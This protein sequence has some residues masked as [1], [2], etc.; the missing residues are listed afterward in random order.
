M[1]SALSIDAVILHGIVKSVTGEKISPDLSDEESDLSPRIRGFLQQQVQEALKFGRQIVEVDGLSTV[2]GLIRG[3]WSGEHDLVASSRALAQMLQDSQPVVSPEG[4]LMVADATVDGRKAFVIAKLEHE[5]GAQAK[6]EPNEEGRMVYTM[7]FLDDLFF[8]TGSRVF[9]IGYF[10]MG[11][12]LLD[13]LVVDRQAAG[14]AVARYFRE[15]YLGCGWKE[16]PELATERFMNT[17]QAWIDTVD[18]P[19]KRSRYQVGLLS[20]LQSQSPGLSVGGFAAQHIDLDDRDA[21]ERHAR[22]AL[23]AAEI[24]K[25]LELVRARLA[26]VRIDTASGAVIMAPP[27]RLQDGTVTVESDGGE[28]KSRIVVEDDITKTSGTGA[29]KS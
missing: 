14:H 23:P 19:E 22:Q 3:F 6:R 11:S 18:D 12:G 20:E 7:N 21:F 25:D 8:T 15:V 1:V 26:S 16:R 4:L 13:G 5:K 9:K 29:F 28:G 2:P 27:E 10:P 24:P 17:V